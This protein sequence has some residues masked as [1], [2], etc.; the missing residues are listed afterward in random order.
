MNKVSMIRAVAKDNLA[1]SNAQIKQEVKARFNTIVETNLVIYT[2]GS[3]A[4]RTKNASGC[5]HLKE[6]ARKLILAAGDY[7]NAQKILALAGGEMR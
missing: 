4:E 6:L 1:L 5:H 3:E 7:R 2:L